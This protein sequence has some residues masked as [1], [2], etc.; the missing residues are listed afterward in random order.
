MRRFTVPLAALLSVLLVLPAA[1][2]ADAPPPSSPNADLYGKSLEAAVEAVRTYGV[3]DNPE[4]RRRV[5]RIGYR[6]AQASGFRDFPISFILADMAE[7]NAFALPGGQVFV[8]R[9]I[10]AL[11]LT[12]DELAALLGHE[13]AHVVFRHGVKM[14]RRATLLNVLSQAAVIGVMINSGRQ[15]TRQTKYPY[16]YGADPNVYNPNRGDVVTGTYAASMILSELLLRSYSRD[17][18]DQADEAGQRWAA[19]AGFDPH[20]EEK[21]ME[22]LGSRLPDSKD[23]GYWR[24]HPFF[25]QRIA[26]A[27]VRGKDLKEGDARADEEFRSWT[28]KEILDLGAQVAKK[29]P[30]QRLVEK[31]GG[32]GVAAW[33]RDGAASSGERS[34]AA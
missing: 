14:E 28:Q 30:A 26:A 9:G 31:L 17:F 2:R 10:L 23:Y 34:P 8:T 12:D 27:R 3:W 7:P 13:I 24:T 1:A 16:P 22:V 19:E 15:Q 18:E 4:Q 29:P 25:D 33:Y 21:L 5:A 32:N 20:G 6:V 11:G